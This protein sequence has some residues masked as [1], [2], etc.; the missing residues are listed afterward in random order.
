MRRARSVA[1]LPPS[2]ADLGQKHAGRWISPMCL[3]ETWGTPSWRSEARV[4]SHDR[5]SRAVGGRHRLSRKVAA[6]ID[7]TRRIRNRSPR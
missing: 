5:E 6:E 2:Y 3:I 7:G 4:A 1:D